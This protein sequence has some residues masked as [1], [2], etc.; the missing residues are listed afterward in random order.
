MGECE[1]CTCKAEV[2]PGQT[3]IVCY[4]DV[5]IYLEFMGKN[6]DTFVESVF[7]MEEENINPFK[8]LEDDR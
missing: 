2:E 3:G 5:H 1:N 6:E 7:M 8:D 4:G